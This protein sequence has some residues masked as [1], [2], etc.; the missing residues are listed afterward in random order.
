MFCS[1]TIFSTDEAKA[2]RTSI[3][4]AVQGILHESETLSEASLAN[5]RRQAVQ[6]RIGQNNREIEDQ[7]AAATKHAQEAGQV[8]DIGISATPFALPEHSAVIAG[9]PGNA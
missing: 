6:D 2:T 5:G 3:L 8:G 1:V 4:A 9:E 7:I